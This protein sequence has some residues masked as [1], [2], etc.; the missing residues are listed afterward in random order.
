MLQNGLAHARVW[1]LVDARG[2]VLGR[3]AQRISVALRGKH[4][5]NFHPTADIGDYVVVINAKDVVVTGR[6][7]TQKEYFSH[8]GYPGGEK[9]IPYDKYIAEHP[10]GPLYKA[11]WGTMPRTRLAKDQIKRLK[12]FEGSEHP[13]EANILRSYLPEAQSQADAFEAAA[14]E[15]EAEADAPLSPAPEPAKPAK[16]LKAPKAPKKK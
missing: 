12:L 6:K 13:Y 4:K 14:A 3:L 2:K 9:L 8:S 5:P 16:A 10:T 1:H 11:V 15:A 7:R